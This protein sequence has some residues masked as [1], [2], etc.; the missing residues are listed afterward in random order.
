[1][2]IQLNNQ[3]DIGKFFAFVRVASKATFELNPDLMKYLFEMAR[4]FSE[5]HNI[6]IEFV[7]PSNERLVA[8]S[9]GG[10]AIG[11]L[12]GYLLASLPGAAIGAV[13]GAAGGVALAHV[14]VSIEERQPGDMG[15]VILKII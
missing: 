11:A 14:K 3:M 1:M 9:S 13:V 8:F 10:A 7:S 12:T 2:A 6:S 4:S 15:P 5:T